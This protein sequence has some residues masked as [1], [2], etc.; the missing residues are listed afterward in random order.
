[1][2]VASTAL[3]PATT[4]SNENIS[5]SEA[6]VSARRTPNPDESLACAQLI[7]FRGAH[8]SGE[9]QGDDQGKDGSASLGAVRLEQI[10]HCEG[11][12]SAM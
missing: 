6:E 11:L 10:V 7:G 9:T 2:I 4:Q 5:D 3:P 8:D 1:M 12:V